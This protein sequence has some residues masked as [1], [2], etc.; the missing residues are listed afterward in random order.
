MSR[1]LRILGGR[2]FG[3]TAAI[4]L[5]SGRPPRRFDACGLIELNEKPA[6]TR[7]RAI[8]QCVKS[9]AVD[10]IIVDGVVGRPDAVLLGIAGVVIHPRHARLAKP[11]VDHAGGDME[12][13]EFRP[14][15]YPL[16]GQTSW[17]ASTCIKPLGAR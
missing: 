9:R 14:K 1:V 6:G 4:G 11:A 8:W 13:N 15:A 7:F 16:S 10:F 3:A 2:L 17:T 12:E 5:Q